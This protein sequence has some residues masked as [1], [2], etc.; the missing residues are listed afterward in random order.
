MS[1][2]FGCSYPYSYHQGALGSQQ[3]AAGEQQQNKR[4]SA[5][6]RTGSGARCQL[7]VDRSAPANGQQ[8]GSRQGTATSS[9]LTAEVRGPQQPPPRASKPAHTHA[10]KQAASSPAHLHRNLY[11]PTGRPPCARARNRL[12]GVKGPRDGGMPG[13]AGRHGGQHGGEAWT[14][15]NGSNHRQK[16]PRPAAL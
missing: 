15:G 8:S 9:P 10:P 16:A 7:R 14:R 1:T 3:R 6:E 5:D 13:P 11:Q 4:A 2:S 12:H